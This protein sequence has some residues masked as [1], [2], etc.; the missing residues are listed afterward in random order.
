MTPKK[1]MLMG[2]SSLQETLLDPLWGENEPAAKTAT[3]D[4]GQQSPKQPQEGRKGS[5]AKLGTNAANTQVV[6]LGFSDGDEQWQ[7]HAG[8]L[9]SDA[10]DKVPQEIKP[11][12]SDVTEEGL[13][14]ETLPDLPAN[15]AA[16]AEKGKEMKKDS[17]RPK[18]LF[19]HSTKHSCIC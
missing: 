14:P 10:L 19:S 2:Y 7:P 17:S 5:A 13:V 1:A 6:S 15:E 4:E 3:T 12:D 9:I 18:S 16:S 8:S 11:A